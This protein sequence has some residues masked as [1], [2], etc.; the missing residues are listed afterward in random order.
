MF[1]P[2]CSSFEMALITKSDAQSQRQASAWSHIF[3]NT[4]KANGGRS[5]N[6]KRTVGGPW[7]GDQTPHSMC[8]PV[9]PLQ[10]ECN[11]ASMVS[12]IV[13]FA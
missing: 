10:T 3:T 13:C 5:N 8:G 7:V 1:F 6:T 12:E 2:S 4:G 11:L 9:V